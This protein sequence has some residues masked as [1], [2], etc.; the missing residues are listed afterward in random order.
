MTAT[1]LS[2]RVPYLMGVNKNVRLNLYTRIRLLGIKVSVIDAV[3]NLKLEIRWAMLNF[4][5]AVNNV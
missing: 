3:I 2:G 4:P 5:R 1:Q